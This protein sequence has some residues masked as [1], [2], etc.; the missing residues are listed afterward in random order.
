MGQWLSNILSHEISNCWSAISR[1]KAAKSIYHKRN[2]CVSILYAAVWWQTSAQAC[3]E[4]AKKW[5]KQVIKISIGPTLS[6][7]ADMTN[8]L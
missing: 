3:A 7:T 5:P 6:H 8:V 1:L 2:T 4:D